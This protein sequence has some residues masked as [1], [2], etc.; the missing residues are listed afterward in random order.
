MFRHAFLRRDGSVANPPIACLYSPRYDPTSVSI[1]PFPYAAIVAAWHVNQRR[2]RRIQDA[3]KAL[4]QRRRYKRQT[5]TPPATA[6]TIAPATERRRTVL[7]TDADRLARSRNVAS[8]KPSMTPHWR[9]REP[10]PGSWAWMSIRSRQWSM[11][12]SS[13]PSVEGACGAIQSMTSEPIC[14]TVRG[15]PRTIQPQQDR[16]Q[17]P[18]GTP[19]RF[20]SALAPGEGRHERL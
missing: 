2:L 8:R 9:P 17:S 7:R 11:R 14:S 3:S 6:Y 4:P 1:D 19:R 16:A 12:A 15:L 13:E 20:Q 10:Q 5:E 18:S